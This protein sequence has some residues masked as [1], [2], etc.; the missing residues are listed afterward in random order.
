M[1]ARAIVPF[2]STELCCPWCQH[3]VYGLS[4]VEGVVWIRCEGKVE[5]GGRH[6]RC[7]AHLHVVAARFGVSYAFACSAEEARQAK[8]EAW[9]PKEL[10][11]RLGQRILHGGGVSHVHETAGE[12]AGSWLPSISMAIATIGPLCTLPSMESRRRRRRLRP[13]TAD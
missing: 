6:E 3:P 12:T 11:R 9:E 4:L 2:G 1:E 7:G 5:A 13:A 10:Y 8:A